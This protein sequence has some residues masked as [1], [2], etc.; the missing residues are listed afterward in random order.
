MALNIQAETCIGCTGT[1][2][3]EQAAKGYLQSSRIVKYVVDRE[4]GGTNYVEVFRDS[5][6]APPR[7]EGIAMVEE[8]LASDIGVDMQ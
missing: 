5:I 4:D 7:R 3:V 8:E 2:L 1:D 6:A